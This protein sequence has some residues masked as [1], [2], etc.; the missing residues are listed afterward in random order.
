MVLISPKNEVLLLHRVKTSTSFASAHVFP[1]GNL[2]KQ[3]GL[4][5]PPEDLSRHNDG[6]WYRHAAIRE[7]FE[8]SG[9][10]LAK[11]HNSG[12]MLAV[13]EEQREAGRRAIHQHT[14]TFTDW[15]KEQNPAAVPD[16]GGL[17]MIHLLDAALMR[18]NPQRAIDSFYAVDHTHKCPQTVYDTDVSLLLT[19]AIGD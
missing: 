13:S 9:I 15:L 19:L 8:E 18:D 5:P 2:S 14:I 1:G 16:I 10:L 6:P 4:C 3:D 11:D 12:K 17:C 7:L